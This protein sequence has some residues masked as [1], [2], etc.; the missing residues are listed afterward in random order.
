MTNKEKALKKKI[1]FLIMM[2]SV[3]KVSQEKSAELIIEEI[4]KSNLLRY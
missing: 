4:K 3:G 1:E 2:V